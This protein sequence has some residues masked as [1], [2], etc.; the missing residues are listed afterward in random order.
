[1]R[2]PSTAGPERAKSR[3]RKTITQKGRGPRNPSAA[4]DKTHCDVAQ[5]IRERDKALEREKAT[6]EVLRV[7]SNSLGDLEPVFQ[8]ILANATRIC[9]A[10]YGNMWLCEGELFR[11]GGQYGW[12]PAFEGRFRYGTLFRPG[13]NI[14]AVQAIRTRKPVQVAD[15][16]TTRA[17]LNRDPLVVE[18]AD[19]ARARTLLAVPMFK[20]DEPV[21]VIIIFRKKVRRFTDKQIDL[22]TNFAAQAV[23]A[24]ENTRLL[25]ELRQRTDDLS[26]A[27]EQQTATSEVLKVISSSPGEL[28]PVFETMLSNMCRICDAQLSAFSYA[29]GTHSSA[30]RCTVHLPPMPISGERAR[31]LSWCRHHSGSN[32][33]DKAGIPGCWAET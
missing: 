33:E 1:M 32:R 2:R 8:S 16:R 21:G 14:P 7:I 22:V 17:Y 26:E 5:L 13:P 29:R 28:Q 4:D 10:S 15:L 11:S 19:V 27:L 12:L 3:R 24:I 23:I 6:A 20:E 30:S 25:N 31:D 9:D 18:G